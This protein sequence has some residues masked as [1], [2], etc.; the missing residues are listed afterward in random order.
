[1]D[2]NELAKSYDPKAVE[3]DWYSFWMDEGCFTPDPTR[4]GPTFCI[5]IPPPNVTGVLHMG[6]ALTITIQDAIVRWRRMLGDNTLYLPGTD[7]A[8]IATQVVVERDLR[9][10]EGLT[11]H[12]IGREKFIERV[13]QWKEHHGNRITDQ[14]KVLGASL[15]W[16]R[17]RFTMDEGLSRAVREVFVRLYEEGLI[18]RGHRMIN[19]CPR[20][21]TALSD[22]EVQHEEN[23]A[24]RMWDFAYPIEGGGEIVVSTT[25]PET[26]LGDTAV[27]VHPDDPRYEHLIGKMIVHPLLDR[28]FPIIAD[29][30]LVD[31]EFGTGAVKVTPAHDFNDFEVGKRH[32]L[33]FISL[34][35][36]HGILTDVCGPF[37]GLTVMEAR[38]KVLAA[39]DAKGLL[40][41]EKPHTMAIGRCQR[42]STVLEPTLS[43]QWFVHTEPLAK[44]ALDAVLEGRTTIHPESQVKVYRHWLENIQDWCISRQLWW[45]HRIP[46]WY[47]QDCGEVVV[48][49]E[50]PSTCPKCGSHHLEQDEDV[51]DTWFSSALWPFSTLGWP[52]ATPELEAFYPTDVMETGYDILFFWVARMMMMGLHFMGDVPF[53]RVYL[54]GM[55]RD[56]HGEK[57]S[58]TRGNV[59]D[60]LE[61]TS[62]YGADA[63]RFTLSTLAVQGRD[64]KLDEKW[65][66]GY[67]AFGNKIWNAA[68]FTISRLEG[69]E[70]TAE[71]PEELSTVDRWILGVLDELAETVHQAMDGFHLNEASQAVYHFFWHQFCDWYL[72]MSKAALY[73]EDPVAKRAAQWT[74]CQVLDDSL[75]LL[76][77]FMPYLTE[78]LWQHLPRLEGDPESIMLAAFPRPGRFPRA[79]D[80]RATME[81]AFEVITATR[82]LKAEC[83]VPPAS[84]PKI[85]LHVPDPAQRRA[86]EEVRGH[87]ISQIRLQGLEILEGGEPPAG[88][89]K[90]VVAGSLEIYMPLVGLIDIAAERKRLEKAIAKNERNLEGLRR[91]LSNEAFLTR[92]PADV[93]EKE[94]ARAEELEATLAKLRSGLEQLEA[95]SR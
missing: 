19:W 77:P 6:H 26:M 44:P 41:G 86:M 76:H 7:H 38:E 61:L 29:E 16:T 66:A 55:I 5:V 13:W 87:L 84:K 80:A 31:P 35:D 45:G 91:K 1:M 73:G 72:E 4:E 37:A 11:R 59:I 83:G 20:C 64:I 36:E 33:E 14:L 89:A 79:L 70:R 82:N 42:C 50:T 12:D 17:E 58:K 21:T 67:R 47:C 92:A 63:L 81:L 25:R 18:Y 32:G 90:A 23:V 10:K 60:P 78:E 46:A 94:K 53:R 85:E 34:L 54:H 3:A 28:K 2:G 22:L 15:D 9:E 65:V 49:R 69:F 39:L 52:D 8:G 51:L 30:I 62:K 48:A 27:A 57:M 43:W 88:S 24:G 40:R 93:V 95:A 74:I 75:R 68:R 71:V 56:R